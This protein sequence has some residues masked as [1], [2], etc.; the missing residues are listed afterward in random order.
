VLET[1]VELGIGV[2][3]L[4][5]RRI[6]GRRIGAWTVIGA[7]SVVIDDIPAECTA[8]GTPCRVIKRRK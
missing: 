2:N 5:G 8:V 1:G 3:V 6:G 7:G 4:R